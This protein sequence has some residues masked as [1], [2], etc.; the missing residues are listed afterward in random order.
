MFTQLEV[1]FEFKTS[2]R[3]EGVKTRKSKFVK[4]K[5]RKIILSKIYILLLSVIN[6]TGVQLHVPQENDNKKL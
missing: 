6:K 2:P 3:L 1:N 4:K 5:S